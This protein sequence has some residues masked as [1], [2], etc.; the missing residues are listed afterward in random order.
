MQEHNDCSRDGH[1][2]LGP[3]SHQY[4]ECWHGFGKIM[5]CVIDD[6]KFDGEL[7]TCRDESDVPGKI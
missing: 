3:C 1:F 7:L 4:C 6:Y 5:N 2:A